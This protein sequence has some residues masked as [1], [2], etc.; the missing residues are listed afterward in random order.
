MNQFQPSRILNLR[1]AICLAAGVAMNAG[2]AELEEIVV[3]AQK[4]AE[5]LQKVPL[6]IVAFSEQAIENKRISNIGDIAGAT[7]NFNY[8]NFGGGRPEFTIRGIG[9]TGV[10]R[11][12][13]DNAVITFVDEV[14]VSRASASTF[15]LFDLEQ[16]SVLRGPQGTLFGKNVVGG[17]V[18]ITT[19]KPSL[20][21]TEGKVKVT[22]GNLGLRDFKGY[23][24]GS[25]SDSVAA[26]LTVSSVDRDGFGHDTITGQELEDQNSKSARAQVLVKANEDL[27]LLF[28]AEMSDESNNGGVLSEA[29][30]DTAL[31]PT[32]HDPY[33]SSHGIN[34]FVDV[35]QEN[36]SLKAEWET[37]LGTLTSITAHRDT[38]MAMRESFTAETIG[39]SGSFI[40]DAF[41]QGE[42]DKQFTQEIRLASNNDGNYNWVTGLY[43][44]NEEIERYECEDVT[45]AEV[46]FVWWGFIN[47]G[48]GGYGSACW[49]MQNET[50]GWAVFWD[51]SYQLSDTF[52]MRAGF[53]Y[54]EEDKDN[55]TIATSV[56]P[57]TLEDGT[58]TDQVRWPLGEEYDVSSSDTFSGF[59]P[60]LVFEW[61]VA[62][63][64]MLYLSGSKGFK[65]G[66]FDGKLPTA[67]QTTVP[68]KEEKATS[69]EL[70][71]KSQWLDNSLQFNAA[72][73]HSDFEDM[74]RL[75]FDPIIAGGLIVLNAGEA[76][77]KGFEADL[78]WLA[79]DN[80]E[81]NVA[82]GY[83]DAVFDQFVA[84]VENRSGQ[85]L[86]NAPENKYNLSATYQVPLDGGA[87]LQF[88][89]DYNFTDDHH[90]DIEV[91]P[92]NNQDSYSLVNANISY[93]TAD[94][95]W[96]A[97][98]WGKN[99]TD[100]VYYLRRGEFFGHS[101]DKPAAPRTYGLSVSYS[102]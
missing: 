44:I 67:A 45:T 29:W 22:A 32:D 88:Y 72:L 20:D 4:R 19:K 47:G 35:E 56:V 58:V 1:T 49:D 53:R 27:E 3:T 66:G 28:T 78:T 50:D 68:F 91:V 99:L 25:L 10:V 2:A 18:S 41:T 5:D 94:E 75:V 62:E 34:Q 61:T 98:L 82:Y 93:T 51:G 83:L 77:I 89:A 60:R 42:T 40:G 38:E 84:G 15:E 74:Q 14:Y 90:L 33:T 63:D 43:Y 12:G 85:K 26:K 86:P 13:L 96:N 37:S 70:G 30:W 11:A 31:T 8:S 48:Q 73:F 92:Q 65:S 24:N 46:G 80:L 23:V 97:T 59:T 102:F 87:S 6:S 100:E 76:T 17:A 54:T 52:A 55:R 69:Y 9:T 101:P 16:I 64:A 7:P 39:A 81:L 21:G 71:L 57:F 95:K 36:F 79:T